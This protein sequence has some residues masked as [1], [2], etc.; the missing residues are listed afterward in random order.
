M[1]LPQTR[2]DA[3]FRL[4]VSD[5]ARAAALLGDY[6]PPEVAERLD[7]DHA[8][9]HIE[10]TA[11]D[12]EGRTTQADAIFRVRM[13]DG[14]PARVYI[15]L[16]HKAQA[17]ARTPLQLMRYILRLWMADIESGDLPAGRLPLVIPMVFFNGRE[18]WT[19]P[20]SIADMIAAPEGLGHL[21]RA[22]GTYALH[23]LSRIAP[24]ELSHDATVRSALLALARAFADDITDAEAD[25]LV[26]AI[27]DTEFGRYILMYIAEQVSL[28]PERI[29][30]ALR[31]I[32]ADP[33]EVEAL[34]GTAA[35]VWFEQGE[36]RGKAAGIAEGRTT[37][38]AEGRTA[39]I[40]EG[41]TAGIAEGRTAGVAEGKSETLA[42]LIE[43]RFGPPPDEVRSRIAGAGPEQLDRWLDAVLDAPTLDAVFGSDP[44]H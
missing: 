11:I 28:P 18:P 6:L 13:K 1:P 4:L 7:P 31:R 17:D 12:G 29:A 14:A 10:G 40:A 37:G 35:Q 42:R 30:A 39:G 23:D 21:A 20:R 43:R 38:I 24:E 27:A 3:L 36:A 15:L 32:G 8:P 41:R 22:F 26:V 25:A 5:P 44:E 9:E 19:V 2:H 33:D 16:E 34:M